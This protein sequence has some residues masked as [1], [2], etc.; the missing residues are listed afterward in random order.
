MCVKQVLE[1]ARKAEAEAAALKSQLKS[2]STGSKRALREMEAQVQ[3]S[4]TVSQKCEREYITLRDAIKHL[5]EGWK[6]D[7]ERLKKEMQE[8]EGKLRKQAEETGEKHRK[9][10]EQVK[11][12]RECHSLVESIRIEEKLVQKEWEESLRAQIDEL[13]ESLR[14]SEHDS[15]MAGKTAQ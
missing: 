15:S 1:R 5:S 4:T 11:K 6:N 2:E 9:F 3:Q 12:E 14:R 13:R 7:V 8:K 10:M